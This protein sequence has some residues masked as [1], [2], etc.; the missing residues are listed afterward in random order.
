MPKK[1]WGVHLP[2]PH[3]RTGAHHDHFK[4]QSQESC[5]P[6]AFLGF[7]DTLEASAED[8]GR[9]PLV[10][11]VYFHFLMFMCFYVF[12]REVD[13]AMYKVGAGS[14]TLPMSSKPLL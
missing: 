9:D 2:T 13:V 12:L 7:W 11:P 8:E 4:T 5:S 6:S 3:S 14:E 10:K 1:D